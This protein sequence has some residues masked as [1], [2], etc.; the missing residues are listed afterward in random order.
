VEGFFY[1]LKQKQWKEIRL[2]FIVAFMKLV[3]VCQMMKGLNIMIGYV[4]MVSIE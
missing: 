1:A 3:K 4:D 2:Y